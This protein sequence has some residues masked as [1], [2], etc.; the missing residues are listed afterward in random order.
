MRAEYSP[1]NTSSLS[2]KWTILRFVLVDKQIFDVSNMSLETIDVYN[3]REYVQPRPL[4]QNW[5][6]LITKTVVRSCS[7][8]FHF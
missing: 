1:T 7:P 6:L 8:A 4:V 2:A 3:G 5:R